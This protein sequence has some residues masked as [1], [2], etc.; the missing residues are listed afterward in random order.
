MK[1][2]AETIILEEGLAQ[3][4]F[5]TMKGIQNEL[6]SCANYVFRSYFE[7][8]NLAATNAIEFNFRTASCKHL[9]EKICEYSTP[10]SSQTV[11]ATLFQVLQYFL[12]ESKELLHENY[13]ISLHY[14]ELINYWICYRKSSRLHKLFVFEVQRLIFSWIETATLS[15]CK[16]IQDEAM[17]CFLSLWKFKPHI[18]LT[19][20]DFSDEMHRILKIAVFSYSLEDLKRLA[21]DAVNLKGFGKVLLSNV[22][23]CADSKFYENPN[24]AIEIFI[25]CVNKSQETGIKS[26]H[27]EIALK[28][29]TRNNLKEFILQLLENASDFCALEESDLKTFESCARL[30][31]PLNICKSSDEIETL[32][33][34]CEK[35]YECASSSGSSS[36]AY[37]LLLSSFF[38][39]LSEL[40]ASLSNSIFPYICDALQNDSLSTYEEIG[41]LK[42][43]AACCHHADEM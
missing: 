1:D 31:V 4:A 39:A 9:V 38:T 5:S 33:R 12:E 26:L 30:I 37:L 19:N 17:S 14:L 20:N 32:R 22:L 3:I 36:T 16:E 2:S 13:F 25:A 10:E 21:M 34:F 29:S 28:N 8:L 6:H 24:D 35:L 11:C 42:A 18:I 23:S 43:V 41:L 7:S 15:Y 27:F 40:G